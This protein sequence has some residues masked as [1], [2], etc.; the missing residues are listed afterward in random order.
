[1]SPK[2]YNILLCLFTCKGVKNNLRV[3]TQWQKD[4]FFLKV[5]PTP[6]VGNMGH[7]AG[8]AS[9]A[10]T[11]SQIDHSPTPRDGLAI[12]CT[13]GFTGGARPDAMAAQTAY[14]KCKCT[15]MQKIHRQ[16]HSWRTPPCLQKFRRAD[17]WKKC[18]GHFFSAVQP[19][20]RPNCLAVNT[21]YRATCARHCDI[22]PLS[23]VR[24]TNV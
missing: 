2:R 15:Q 22:P 20:P 17:V 3:P 21:G 11:K 4:H 23:G 8:S 19:C 10:H 12:W 5:C 9:T 14:Y 24:Q 6:T 7:L 1:M 16:T 13:G 18:Q